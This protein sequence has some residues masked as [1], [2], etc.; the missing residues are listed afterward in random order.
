MPNSIRQPIIFIA[1][2]STWQDWNG[3]LLHFFGEEPIPY[4]PDEAD[5]QQV[6]LNVVQLPT[7]IVY[8]PPDPTEFE[9]WQ[10]WVNAFTTVVNGPTK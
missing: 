10:D 3:A 5:W 9:T 7:F 2:N 1:E 8:S 4:M 6:A